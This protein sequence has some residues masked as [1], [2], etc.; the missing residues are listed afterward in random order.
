MAMSKIENKNSRYNGSPGSCNTIWICYI[1]NLTFHDG[2]I[3]HL[4]DNISKHTARKVESFPTKPG[5]ASSA[6]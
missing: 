4:H 2:S 1:C 3:A 5:G 6:N